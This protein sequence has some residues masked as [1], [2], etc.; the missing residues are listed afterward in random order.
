MLRNCGLDHDDPNT[1]SGRDTVFAF[2]ASEWASS[3]VV[4]VVIQQAVASSELSK[5]D[6]SLLE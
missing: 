5:A 3:P 4:E 1:L 2:H 6:L